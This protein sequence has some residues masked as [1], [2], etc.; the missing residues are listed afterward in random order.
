VTLHALAFIVW[1]VGSRSPARLVVDIRGSLR[2][3]SEITKGLWRF[4]L[5]LVLLVAGALLML[6][7]TIVDV[8]TEF[9]TL[10]TGAIL[11]GLLV[12]MLIGDPIRAHITTR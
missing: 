9:L 6:S 7:I 2:S 12:E 4:L 10:E 8:R 11:V 3:P 5:G 1:N